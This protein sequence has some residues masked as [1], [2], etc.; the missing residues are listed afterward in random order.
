[1]NTIIALNTSLMFEINASS[2][3]SSIRWMTQVVGAP[4][5]N[6]AFVRCV[7]VVGELKSKFGPTLDVDKGYAYIRIV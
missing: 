4:A 7:H 1:M 2:N 6:V 5:A 3:T